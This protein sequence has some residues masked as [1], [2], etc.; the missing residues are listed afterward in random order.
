VKGAQ[1]RGKFENAH[2]VRK[3]TEIFHFEYSYQ[4]YIENSKI[5]KMEYLGD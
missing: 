1:M 5:F 3:H 2:E 4:E